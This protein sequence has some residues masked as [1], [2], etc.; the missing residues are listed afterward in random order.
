LRDP[1]LYDVKYWGLGSHLCG[2]ADILYVLRA[3]HSAG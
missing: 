1:T 2:M 3:I